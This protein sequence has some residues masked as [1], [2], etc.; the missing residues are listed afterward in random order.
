MRLFGFEIVR[1]K[2]MPI[3]GS[4]ELNA[5]LVDVQERLNVLE[6]HTGKHAR[7]DPPHPDNA[8][9]IEK[10]LAAADQNPS[11]RGRN[12]KLED[13]DSLFFGR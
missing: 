2:G 6:K 5:G 12:P 3:G 8:D 7:I 9:E 10:I 13:A 1:V 4:R 11:W